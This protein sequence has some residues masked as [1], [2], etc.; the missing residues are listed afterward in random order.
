MALP[1]LFASHLFDWSF[2]VFPAWVLLIS[3]YILIDNFQRAPN[4][5]RDERA[6]R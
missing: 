3:A 5:R 2:A 4:D 6:A 1:L